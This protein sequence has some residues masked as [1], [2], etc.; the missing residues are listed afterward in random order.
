M[1]HWNQRYAEPEYAYG[2]DPNVFFKSQLDLL[3]PGRLF[4]AAAGEGRNAVYAMLQG[5]EVIA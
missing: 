4:F 2:T 3:R 1:N 5:R